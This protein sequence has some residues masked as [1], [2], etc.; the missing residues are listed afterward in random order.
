VERIQGKGLPYPKDLNRRGDLLINFDI[1]FPE[2]LNS[3]QREVL[4]D[5]LS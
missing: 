1:Q 3:S 4:F 2:Q 5:V